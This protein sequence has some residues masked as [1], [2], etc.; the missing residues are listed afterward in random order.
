MGA[1]MLEPRNAV[2]CR[3]R[4]NASS[5]KELIDALYLIVTDFER[6]GVRSFVGSS[7]GVV[8]IERRDVTRDQWLQELYQLADSIKANR[9]KVTG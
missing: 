2:N 8:E 4:L 6:E 3:I 7:V 1:E 5:D 9:E